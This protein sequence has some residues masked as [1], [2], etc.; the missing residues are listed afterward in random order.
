MPSRGRVLVIMTNSYL[1][2]PAYICNL[3]LEVVCLSSLK[4]VGFVVKPDL[5]RFAFVTIDNEVHIGISAC[6]SN[7]AGVYPCVPCYFY[8]Y[9]VKCVMVW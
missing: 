5:I 9:N 6:T 2:G 8:N 3:D 7:I 4:V 1:V